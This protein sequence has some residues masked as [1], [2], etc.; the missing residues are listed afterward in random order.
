MALIEEGY[1]QFQMNG[2]VRQAVKTK[3]NGGRKAKEEMVGKEEARVELLCKSRAGDEIC[4]IRSR[5]T[6]DM[7]GV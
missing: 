3:D 5:S 1:G 7:V 6:I 4:F 2:Q